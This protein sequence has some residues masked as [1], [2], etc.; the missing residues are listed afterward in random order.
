MHSFCF[1]GFVQNIIIEGEGSLAI[2]QA[3]AE[4]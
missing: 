2:S 1:L 4:S 3:I